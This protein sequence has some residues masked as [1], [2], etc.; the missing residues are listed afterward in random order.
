MPSK[1]LV[2]P[3]FFINQKLKGKDKLQ[4]KIVTD[5]N[6]ISKLFGMNHKTTKNKNK[7]KAYGLLLCG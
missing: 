5:D 4:L 3:L 7:C 2:N 1:V 6:M